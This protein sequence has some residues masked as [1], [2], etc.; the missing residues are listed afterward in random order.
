[1][2][3]QILCLIIVLQFV[4]TL[5]GQDS[6]KN[7]NCDKIDSIVQ[8]ALSKVGCEYKY[9]SAGPEH[10]DCSGLMYYTF[11]HFGMKLLRS[12]SE[13]FTMGKKVDTKELRKGDLVFFNRGKGVGHVGI[14]FD[15]D[16]LYNFRFVHATTTRRGVCLDHSYQMGYK[17]TFVGARRLLECDEISRNLILTDL[18]VSEKRDNADD[19]VLNNTQQEKFY[20][21]KKGDTLYSISKRYK[22]T[23]EKL[24]KWNHLKSNQL[25]IGQRLKIV[26]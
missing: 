2:K 20:H 13:Q 11:S 12:S 5:F 3:K 15:V 17:T 14:V 22:V 16:S 8:F 18:S 9:G 19:S 24:M 10:F 1:M 4:I 6:L 26:H 23:I 21:V 25:Q 7:N